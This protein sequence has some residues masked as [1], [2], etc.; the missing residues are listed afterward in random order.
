VQYMSPEQA[1]AKNVGIGT[2]IWS[3]GIVMYELLAGHVPFTGET[4]SHVMVSLMEDKLPPL[5]EHANVLEELDRFVTKTLQK[6]Q[7]ERYRTAGELA[8]DL[9]NFKRKLQQDARLKTWLKSV[10]S[11]KEAAQLATPGQ[12]SAV[13]GAHRVPIEQRG[14]VETTP[15]QTQ[16]TSSAE[17]L[18]REI[19]S[20][21]TLALAAS[22]ILVLGL[23]GLIYVFRNRIG[24]SSSSLSVAN[25]APTPRG[26]TNDEAYRNY[27]QG[28]NLVN[29]RGTADVTKAIEYFQEAIRLDPNYAAPYA[30]LA[31]AYFASEADKSKAE[32]AVEKALQLDSNLAE[33]YAVRGFIE[34]T[35]RWNFTAAE[36]D[37]VHA[38]ELEPNN[39]TAHWVY[40]SL[41]AV[42]SRFDQA[43]KEIETAQAIAPGT[44]A[45]ERD[46]GRLLFYARRY[47]EA[48]MQLK[49][50]IELKP[51]SHSAFSWI[52]RAHEMKGDQAG[53]FDWFIRW[54]ELKHT[55]LVEEYRQAYA[56][57]G[58]LAVKRK[59]LDNVKHRKDYP[60]MDAYEI[61]WNLLM[62]G[63]TTEAFS[64][65]NKA[66]DKRE[67]EV[68]MLNID[69][70]LDGLRDD[71]R[72]ME[73]VKKANFR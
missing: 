35:F 58:W 15:L 67:W 4:P 11:S 30:G 66:V 32:E 48:I 63:E 47:D 54:R 60:G 72:F 65:L 26:T 1:R 27:Q 39:D 68:V 56:A 36:K 69:P 9:K 2:D 31:S 53:A 25:P 13:S 29:T 61:A 44:H 16:P 52:V 41:L 6:N 49:R 38:I 3:L 14:A 50:A 7:K 42:T 28:K 59:F 34:S 17:Y 10:P 37:L 43:I 8:R 57:G 18:V 51:D 23:I 5:R 21:R 73:L 45:Y 19:K 70:Y 24:S 55:D 33:A 12:M 22:V 64:Y 40:A 20:H 71:P 62:L 46:R